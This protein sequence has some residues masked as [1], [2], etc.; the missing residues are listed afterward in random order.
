[1]EAVAEEVT[2]AE[3]ERGVEVFSRRSLAHGGVAWTADDVR[4]E[5]GLHLY[6]ATAA[7]HSILAKDGQPDHRVAAQ[8]DPP[9]R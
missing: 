5:A 8:V 9:G 4:P 6:R 7:G 3:V 2:G 1:M